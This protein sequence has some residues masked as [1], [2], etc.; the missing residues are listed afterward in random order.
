[1]IMNFYNS[2]LLD[3]IFFEFP[4]ICLEVIVYEF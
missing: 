1:M 2:N 3:N 4:Q